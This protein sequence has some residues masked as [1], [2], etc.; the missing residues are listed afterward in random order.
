MEEILNN[1]NVGDTLYTTARG[2][3][4]LFI[5][6]S[7]DGGVKYSINLN[8]KILPLNTINTAVNDSLNNIVINTQ[9]YRNY[10]PNEY[11]TRPCNLSILRELLNL[12]NNQ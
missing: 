9:W 8:P 1:L 2:T 7:Y 3:N 5:S 12:F 4:Y 11:R 10:N 6:R